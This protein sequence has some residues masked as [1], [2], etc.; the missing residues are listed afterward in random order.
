MQFSLVE[1][2]LAQIVK[3]PAMQLAAL[4]PV[5]PDPR[6]DTFQIFEGNRS[7]RAF[8]FQHELLADNVI[9][10]VGKAG[11]FTATF[12]KQALG[13]LCALALQSLSPC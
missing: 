5:S 12:L 2:L 13:R 7:L 4:L 8:G 1:N 3:R 9:H 6:A 11:F 10:V